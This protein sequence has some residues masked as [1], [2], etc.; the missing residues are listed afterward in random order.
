M[1]EELDSSIIR[2]DDAGS[3]FYGNVGLH[4]SYYM[5]PHPERQLSATG[6]FPYQTPH[7]E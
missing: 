4:L 1:V 2:V 7:N 6:M 3:R 5:A